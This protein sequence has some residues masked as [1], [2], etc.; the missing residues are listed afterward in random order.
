M[1]RNIYRTAR[2]RSVSPAAF[3][4]VGLLSASNIVDFRYAALSGNAD[5]GK[6]FN[7]DRWPDDTHESRSALVQFG[8]LFLFAGYKSEKLPIVP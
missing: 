2:F 8:T 3:T 7:K 4:K 5:A 6:Y 1:C